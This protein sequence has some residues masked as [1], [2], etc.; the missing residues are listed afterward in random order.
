MKVST[1]VIEVYIAAKVIQVP[2]FEFM[3]NT[4]SSLFGYP[5]PAAQP[6]KETAAK[7]ATA[8][9]STTVKVKAREKKANAEQDAT[10]CSHE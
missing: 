3:S 10:V 4:R 5:A 9:L 8:V 7:V 6:K 2:K 1:V